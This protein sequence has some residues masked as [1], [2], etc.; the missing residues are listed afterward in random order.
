MFTRAAFF[1]TNYYLED[2]IKSMENDSLSACGTIRMKVM[3]REQVIPKQWKKFLR[4]S[5][6]KLD[7]ID[8]LWHDWSKHSQQLDG[9]VVYD[10]Q[11]SST[12]YI[13]SS[14]AYYV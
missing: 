8:L 12:L 3:R 13:N 6:N 2:F 9:I 1:V 14:R 7:L 4:K 5:E 11:R 10:Y